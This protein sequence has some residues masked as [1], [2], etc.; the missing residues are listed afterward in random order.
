MRDFTFHNPT[1]ILFGKGQIE[2]LGSE[3]PAEARVLLLAGAGSIKENGVLA[4]VQAALGP[5][6][7]GEV[8]GIEPNPDYTSVARALGQVFETKSDFLL[9][10]G[11]GSV[12][13]AAKAVAGLA[14]TEGDGWSVLSKGGR[15]SAALPLGVVLTMP[16]TGTESNAAAAI[17]RR[18][19]KQ[20]VVFINPLCF[21]RFAVLDPETTLSLPARQ[22]ANGVVDAF[23]HVMEQYLTYPSSSVVADRL[24]EGLL[25]TLRELGP[26]ALA[27][28][29]D[30]EVR[31]NLMWCST[32]A[33][34]GLIGAGVSQDWTTH[35]IGHELTA[36][37]GLDHARTLAVVLPAVL[38]ARREQKA[39]KLLQYGARVLGIETG[40]REERIDRAISTTA[41][42]FE[43]MTLPT[44]LSAYQLDAAAIP[45]VIANLKASRRLRMG[46]KLDITLEHA[47]KML[48]LAL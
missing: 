8:W 47:A 39:E 22:V 12:V 2:K 44:K 30:Y 28:P 42:F 17:S 46:E 4:Q 33:L 43:S 14:R 24:A 38:A 9:A 37:F 25:L 40:D 21:P 6:L 26:L 45:L 29:N 1:R 11:G 20:K 3:V 34:N 13:D 19:S 5:R 27:E 16:G 32:L 41:A 7:V 15:F 10:V 48:E 18:E 35:H 31:A 23:V 36:L